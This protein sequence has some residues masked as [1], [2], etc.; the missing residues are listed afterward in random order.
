M[1]AFQRQLNLRNRVVII[2]KPQKNANEDKAS[3]SDPKEDQDQIQ[4]NPR[5]GRG[6]GIIVNKPEI[7]KENLPD[8][9]VVNKEQKKE[10]IRTP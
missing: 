2:S 3:T 4:V 8:K 10:K 1:V 7:T 6:K 5:S 9:H